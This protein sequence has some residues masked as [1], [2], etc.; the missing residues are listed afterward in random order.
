MSEYIPERAMFVC[1]H[2]DD[3]EFG[4]AG[5][6]AK[7]AAHGC[8]VT[9]VMIT[10]GNAGSHDKEMTQARL[11]EIRQEEQREAARIC[12]V[13]NCVFLGY[14]DGL[15]QPT[16]ELR[17]QIV[18]LIRQ[19][20]P[21][22][23]GA[24]DPTNFFPS[25]DYINHPDHRAAGTATID[26]AFPAAEMGLLYPDM[27]EEGLKGHK[28]NYVYLFFTGAE[29]TNLYVD[30]SD[31]ISTKIESLKAHK[32]QMGEWDPTDLITKWAAETGKTVGFAHAE[33]FRRIT[34]KAP[35]PEQKEAADE[36]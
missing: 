23:V 4:I 14:D 5:T 10:D 19:Y 2:P 7:W 32:S 26:A 31:Y 33:R 6:A 1:A 27:A 34:L 29:K 3:L 21:N 20:R 28:I 18:R 12:G 35:E 15:L 8:E 24:M 16:M 9:Y 11:A 30:I 25:D 22:V 36:S 13:K 17:K